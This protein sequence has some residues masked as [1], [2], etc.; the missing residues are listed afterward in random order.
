MYLLISEEADRSSSFI[1]YELKCHSTVSHFWHTSI[2]QTIE[3]YDLFFTP[4][5]PQL[6]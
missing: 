4:S 2:E 1:W 3:V 5:V 6:L